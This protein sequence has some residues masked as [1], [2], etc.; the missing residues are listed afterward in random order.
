MGRLLA[1]VQMSEG[2]EFSTL[3]RANICTNLKQPSVLVKAVARTV[4]KTH[5]CSYTSSVTCSC[6]T[7]LVEGGG[8]CKNVVPY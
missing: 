7:V 1:H 4:E 3:R 5:T 2:A 6:S 8:G